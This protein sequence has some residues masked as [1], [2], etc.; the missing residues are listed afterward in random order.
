MPHFDY[1]KIQRDLRE[2]NV[3]KF[4]KTVLYSNVP[5]GHAES[6]EKRYIEG[7]IGLQEFTILL[8]TIRT[9]ARH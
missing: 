5:S 2:S 9:G 3:A 6:I 7:E 8:E 1:T 4:R